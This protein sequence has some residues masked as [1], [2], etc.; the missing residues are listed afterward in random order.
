[1]CL[2]N[3]NCKTMLCKYSYFVPLLDSRQS[4]YRLIEFSLTESFAISDL[5]FCSSLFYFQKIPQ[6]N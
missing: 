5:I 2:F 6:L 3:Y 1:M 4:F